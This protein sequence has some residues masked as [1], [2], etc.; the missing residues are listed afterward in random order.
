MGTV[1]KEYLISLNL[2]LLCYHKEI[3]SYKIKVLWFHTQPNGSL[4]AKAI[5]VARKNALK[6]IFTEMEYNYYLLH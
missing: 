5:K 4:A 2:L 1:R 6:N 3:V